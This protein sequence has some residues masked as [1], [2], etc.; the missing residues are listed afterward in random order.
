MPPSRPCSYACSLARDCGLVG[1]S[2]VAEVGRKGTSDTNGR[3][4][5]IDSVNTAVPSTAVIFQGVISERKR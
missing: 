3:D 4:T 1:E 5:A 2:L